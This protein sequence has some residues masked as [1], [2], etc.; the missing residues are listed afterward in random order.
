MAVDLKPWPIPALTV[1]YILNMH[2]F[3][4]TDKYLCSKF[5]LVKLDIKVQYPRG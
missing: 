1:T 3:Q 5:F 2:R 4:S